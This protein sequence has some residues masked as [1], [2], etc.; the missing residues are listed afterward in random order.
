MFFILSECLSEAILFLRGS[1]LIFLEISENR[2]K[3]ANTST[4]PTVLWL[5]YCR[6]KLFI[7]LKIVLM[8]TLEIAPPFGYGFHYKTTTAQ[9][10]SESSSATLYMLARNSH[11]TKQQKFEVI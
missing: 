9:V 4:T 11:R 10:K 5:L 2:S 8:V 1:C 6:T 7:S 3:L